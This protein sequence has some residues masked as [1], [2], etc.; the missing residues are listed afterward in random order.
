MAPRPQEEWRESAIGVSL[1]AAQGDAGNRESESA[2]LLEGGRLP[3]G[4]GFLFDRPVPAR[5]ICRCLGSC[6]R[7]VENQ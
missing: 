2:A 3:Q 5:E 7:M 4:T 1:P 6:G